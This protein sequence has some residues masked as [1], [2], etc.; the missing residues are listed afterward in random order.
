MDIEAIMQGGG[1]VAAAGAG[2]T[3]TLHKLGLLTFGKKARNGS[4]D[5]EGCPSPGCHE[6]V[7]TTAHSVDYLCKSHDEL[8]TD[9]KDAFKKLDSIAQEVA[10]QKG[11]AGR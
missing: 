9:M 1:A 8:K 6:L 11:A 7:V 2:I 4:K 5:D 3:F 10:F